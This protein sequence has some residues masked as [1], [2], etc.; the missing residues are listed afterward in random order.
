[1]RYI[2]GRL[3]NE[4]IGTPISTQDEKEYQRLVDFTSQYPDFDIKVEDVLLMIEN[5]WVTIAKVIIKQ[6]RKDLIV[7][8]LFAATKKIMETYSKVDSEIPKYHAMWLNEVLDELERR[9][10]SSFFY[11][12]LITAFIFYIST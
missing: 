8:N 3:L 5:Q 2:C 11:F 1:M 7:P 9:E 4:T 6:S 12:V 10:K